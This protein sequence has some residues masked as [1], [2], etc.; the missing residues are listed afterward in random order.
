MIR[1]MAST[2]QPK[3]FYFIR[4]RNPATPQASVVK[5]FKPSG[6]LVLCTLSSLL[7]KQATTNPD[8]ESAVFDKLILLDDMVVDRWQY[9]QLMQLCRSF[10][11][12]SMNDV[13]DTVTRL[14]VG[15]KGLA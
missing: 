13:S 15:S 2:R 10:N 5:I 11:G 7:D 9:D 8:F 6:G 1:I 12:K 3:R 14:L 4:Y